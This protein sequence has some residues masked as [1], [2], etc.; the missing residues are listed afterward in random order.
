MTISS[1]GNVVTDS[2]DHGTSDEVMERVWQGLRSQECPNDP[3]P[4]INEN[5]V[6]SMTSRKGKGKTATLL[7]ST[8]EGVKNTIGSWLSIYETFLL[9]NAGQISSIESTIRTMTYVLPGRFKD[10]EI[11]SELLYSILNIL[12]LYHDTIVARAVEDSETLNPRYHPSAHSRYTRYYM[13]RDKK[14][15]RIAYILSL[16]RQSELLVEMLARKRGGEKSRWVAVLGIES[17]KAACRLELL[18]CTG[19]R[20][21]TSSVLPEREIDPSTLDGESSSAGIDGN[22]VTEY[23]KMPR[24]GQKL[25][26]SSI[27]SVSSISDVT[28]YLMEN[29]LL[30]EDVAHPQKLVHPLSREG[31]MK[32]IVYIIRPLAYAVLLYTSFQIKERNKSLGKRTKLVVD[33]MPWLTGFALEYICKDSVIDSLMNS[34]NKSNDLRSARTRLTGL[35]K[36]ELEKRGSSMWWWA[37]RGKF[38]DTFTKPM[39]DSIVHRTE[40]IPIINL[41]TV[42]IADYQYLVENYHFSTSTL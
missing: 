1:G 31:K 26:P 15:K 30:P 2:E 20:M 17:V 39:L 28:S 6:N 38:Y 34:S 29:V 36:E 13:A 16:V 33:W 9:K 12:G 5:D 40:N 3:R 4:D 24:T 7:N 32:E 41:G 21:L 19:D 10:A 8:S 18:R 22:E 11:T 37:L 23:W 25:V 42:L 35:E 27:S 14:Y